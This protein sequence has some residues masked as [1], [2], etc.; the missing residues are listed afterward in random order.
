MSDKRNYKILV[1]DDEPDIREM[2][3]NLL[4]IEGF[5]VVI[6]E[7]GAAG[8][9]AVEQNP[10][11]I[12][13]DIMMP[14]MD[15]HAVLKAVRETRNGAELPIIM[16]TAR[17]DVVDIGKALDAG[18]NGFVVKPFDTENLIRTVNGTLARKPSDFYAN[19]EAVDGVVPTSGSGY[20]EGDRI[21][22]LDLEESDPDADIILDACDVDGVYLM[23]ILQFDSPRGTR[24]SSVLVTCESGQAFGDFLNTIFTAGSIGV[25]ACQ[26]YKD[27]LDLPQDLFTGDQKYTLE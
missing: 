24:Q 14:D 8:I 26:I 23:S 2:V 9:A 12:L 4:E 6:A 20:Q 16:V 19:Y 3:Q 25:T 21:I 1:V 27:H 5:D 7:D 17:N 11:L 22:F 15:G 10:D 13:L 18:V